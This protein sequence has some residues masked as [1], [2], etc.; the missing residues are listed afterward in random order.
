[1]PGQPLRLRVFPGA[2]TE[3]T[4]YEDDG[5]SL[6]YTRGG[7]AIRHVRYASADGVHTIE[8]DA[9]SG[10]YRPAPRSLEVSIPFDDEPRRV[11][12]GD[13]EVPRVNADRLDSE[14]SGWT[15]RDGTVI[16]RQPD[17]FNTMRIRI[18]G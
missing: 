4:L 7:S 9:P 14:S 3:T 5:E 11:V 13:Q 17:S 15:M 1:M 18:E 16:V 12:V 2:R 6:D 8:I 10:S